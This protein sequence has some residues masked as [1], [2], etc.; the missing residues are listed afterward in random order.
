MK[1]SRKLFAQLKPGDLFALTSDLFDFKELILYGNIVIEKPALNVSDKIGLPFNAIS[2]Y[3]GKSKIF[4][5]NQAVWHY[6]LIK[7]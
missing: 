2:L 4:I 1:H 7:L 6:E 5:N 3:D